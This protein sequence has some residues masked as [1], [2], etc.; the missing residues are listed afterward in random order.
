M[1]KKY[2]APALEKGLDILELLS[3][4]E[5]GMTQAEI[6]RALDR[7]VSEIF[8]MLIVLMERNYVALDP[9]SDRY[10]LTSLMFEIANRTPVL[11][12][13]TTIANP[14]MQRL[15]ETINQSVHLAVMSGDSVLI[16]AQKD[17]PGYN[18]LSVKLGARMH[19]LEASSGWVI[20]AHLPED[21]LEKYFAAHRLPDGFTEETLR[22]SLRETRR[23]GIEV[24]ESFRLRG[25]TNIS[26]PVTD[27][28]G[29]PIAALTSPYIERIEAG[30]PFAAIVEQIGE[31][32]RT[33]SRQ[34]GGGAHRQSQPNA[35]CCS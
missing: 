6:A 22:E 9:D 29:M 17:S 19:A 24:H 14:I 10:Q 15:A 5:R 35:A 31:A 13:L 28:S 1:S 18:V 34:I 32:A 23:K 11:K 27:H 4:Q 8:R 25:V 30:L 7:S 16:V 2:S 21:A 20:L 26:A 33:L 3:W 12:R